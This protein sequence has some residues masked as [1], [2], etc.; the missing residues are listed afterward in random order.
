MRRGQPERAAH[1]AQQPNQRRHVTTGRYKQHGAASVLP[2]GTPH[3]HSH[4]PSLAPFLLALSCLGSGS[5][6]SS[7]R[8]RCELIF[9]LGGRFLPPTVG[10]S[11]VWLRGAAAAAKR[12]RQTL[13]GSDM[14]AKKKKEE[15]KLVFVLVCVFIESV[16]VLPAQLRGI[17]AS[18]LLSAFCAS[19][20]LP[21]TVNSTYTREG[22]KN[23]K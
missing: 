8:C 20:V 15:K 7:R 22:K 6:R 18:I 9:L 19:P 14:Q 2:P 4:T 10:L 12:D 16:S 3:V 5:G 17:A 1:T 21:S 23:K 11:P 13:I